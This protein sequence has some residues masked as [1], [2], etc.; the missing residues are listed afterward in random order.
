M[1]MSQLPDFRG[2]A[3]CVYLADRE[4]KSGIY[5]IDPEFQMQGDRLF[6]TG[7]TPNTYKE[8]AHWRIAIAWDRIDMYYL[9]DSMDEFVDAWNNKDRANDEE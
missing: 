7:T 1:D 3:L 2:R 5:I 9:A 6:I 4:G 8:F